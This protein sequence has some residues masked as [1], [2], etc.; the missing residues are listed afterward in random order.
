MSAVLRFVMGRAGSG[1]TEYVRGRLKELAGSGARGLYLIVPEQSSFENERAMLRLLGAKDAGRVAVTSFSRL[2]EEV[3]RRYGGGAG[4]RLDDGGRGIFMSLALEQVK[5]RLDFY[6]RN[7]ESEDLVG[8]MLGV[9]AEF[10]MC[11]LSPE[12]I[13]ETAGRMPQGTLKRKM[14]ELSLILSAYDALVSQSYID[15]QDDLTRL[16]EKLLSH[17]FFGGCTVMVDS[18]QSFTVQEYNIMERILVQADDVTV[19]LC[20][21]ALD[22]PEHGMGLFSLVRRTGK[23]LIRLA[24]RN[25]VKA[26]SPV[27]LESGRRFRDPAL[28]ALEAGAYRP[29]RAAWDGD[30]SAVGIYEAKNAY[31]EAAFVS[32]TIRNLVME[33]GFR[34]RDFAVISRNPEK[35]R[36]ILD[37]AL[38]RRDIPYFMDDPQPV[39]AE[40][41]MRLVLSA[42]RAVRFGFRSDDVF[43]YLKTGLAGLSTEQTALLE[44]YVFVWNLSGKKWREEWKENPRGFSEEFTPADRETLKKINALRR[45]AVG[46]LFRLEKNTEQADGERMAAAVYG[47]LR[48]AGAAESLKELA[49]RLSSGGEPALAERELRL[50]DLLMGILDQ[51]ALVLGDRPV[52]RARY[53][54]LL[55]LVIRSGRIASI[56]QGLDEVTVGAANRIRTVEPKVV[57]LIGASQGEFPLAPGGNCVLSDGE[58]REL[59]GMGL[60]L[61]DTME[62]VAVQERFLAYSALSAA[63]ERLFVTYP[64]SDAEGRGV[65]PSTI[66]REVCSVLKKVRVLNEALLSP[67]YFANAAAPAFELAARMWNSGEGLS[68]S[69][70]E[71]FKERGEKERLAAVERAAVKRP[72]RFSDPARARALFGDEMRV[73]ATQIEK[74]HLCRFQYFCRYG[75]GVKERRAAELDA[76][77]YGSLMHYLLER[78]FREVGSERIVSAKP[79]ELR[80]TIVGFLNS[81]AQAKLGGLKNRTPR[82]SYLVSRLA[83][84]AMAVASHIAEE[85]EQSDFDPADFEL[86]IGEDIPPLVIPL[87][88]GGSV[89]I[90]GKVDRVDLMD[91]DGVRYL[92]VVD[93]KTGHRDFR[94]SDIVYGMNMQMLVYLAALCENGGERYGE[95]RPA[96]VLYMPANRPSVLL[97][98]GASDGQREGETAKQLRMDGLVLNDPGVI[99]GMEKKAEGKY[100]PVALKNGA[101]SGK[102]HIVS[103]AEL[104]ITLRYIRSLIS[105]MA[106]TLRRGDVSALP[107]SGRYDACEWCPYRAVCGH[108]R[109]DAVREMKKWDRDAVLAEL[110]KDGEKK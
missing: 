70:K 2:A 55:H 1:K 25:G 71:V 73:S 76:L 19:T 17:R 98:R 4:R 82:F 6:R 46:P 87:P 66:P 72:A 33:E 34:Y 92:R 5:D 67:V 102:E 29:S 52:S 27:V 97:P 10:K 90:D 96:G 11:A 37:G 32:A 93:Y 40:P 53:A 84:A 36:G 91:R 20:T 14:T 49:A 68:A 28:A 18:F 81:Y 105:S 63:S 62:G 110:G 44:N 38:E 39:D 24:K 31:D 45:S 21:D 88:D 26:A 35:Y 89:R 101:P 79:A 74:Y 95:V 59:I 58:R 64:D 41:L 60:P 57:F 22:D 9:S 16:R 99:R 50:W 103:A 30:C 65:P 94:L 77:E 107:L 109:D 8:L 51:T 108:E 3:F 75:L 42:F 85:L 86:G 43:Q 48:D 83:D 100:L 56:P 80:K 15:P 23:N 13:A 7:A 47:L 61:N 12:Q 106:G 69:L 78:L 54:D 104:E